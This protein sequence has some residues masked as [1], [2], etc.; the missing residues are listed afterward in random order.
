M[1]VATQVFIRLL[2]SNFLNIL[3]L[4]TSS[5]CNQKGFNSVCIS[6]GHHSCSNCN[7]ELAKDHGSAF[8]Q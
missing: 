4:V 3:S 5:S 6:E 1:V 7:D 2:N 8:H